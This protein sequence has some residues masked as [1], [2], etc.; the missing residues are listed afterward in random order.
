MLILQA[1]R[2]ALQL[3]QSLLTLQRPNELNPS[4]YSDALV[5][6]PLSRL[7]PLASLVW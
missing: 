5:T 3:T 2:R 4:N 7:K 6:F 1:A